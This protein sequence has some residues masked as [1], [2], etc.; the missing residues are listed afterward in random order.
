MLPGLNYIGDETL[1]EGGDVLILYTN[2]VTQA[3]CDG[4]FFGDEKLVELIKSSGLTP[5]KEV[6]QAIFNNVMECTSGK[7]LDDIAIL[8]ISLESMR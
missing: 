8:A 6:P 2:G 7:L 5:V 4:G 3:K 1:L